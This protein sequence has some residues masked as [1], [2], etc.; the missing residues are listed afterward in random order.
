[1][2]QLNL[3]DLGQV[4]LVQ[5]VE[6]DDIV[7]AVQ[8][9]GG[10]MIAQGVV[11]LLAHHLFILFFHDGVAAEVAGHDDG[12]VAQIDGAA[13]AIGQTAVIEHLQQDV[14]DVGCAFSISSRRTTL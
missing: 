4:L 13:L 1:M 3:G 9:F 8:E 12:G 5:A 6:D 10:E 14:E 7:D 11:N 2:L